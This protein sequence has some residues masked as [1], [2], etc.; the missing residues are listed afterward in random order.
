MV[1]LFTVS[2]GVALMAVHQAGTKVPAIATSC[3]DGQV[4]LQC[5]LS[6][7]LLR[8]HRCLPMCG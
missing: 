4:A 5:S 6:I 3:P 8:I 1:H 2:G 7:T